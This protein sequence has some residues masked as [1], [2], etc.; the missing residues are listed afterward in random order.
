MR[1]EPVLLLVLA[2]VCVGL[3][4]VLWKEIEQGNAAAPAAKRVAASRGEETAAVAP[5]QMP[6]LEAY[7]DILD[8]N[9]FDRSR[10]VPGVEAEEPPA[11]AAEP[12]PLVLTG[13]VITPQTRFALLTDNTPD[14]VVRLKPGESF[15]RWVLVEVRRDGVTLRRGTQFRELPLHEEQK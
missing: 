2:M 11:S 8:R 4:V 5:P 15:G 9:L 3:A 13:V 7:A 14:N 12:L 10:R 6:P 1:R